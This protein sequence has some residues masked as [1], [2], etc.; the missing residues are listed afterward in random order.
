MRPDAISGGG[1]DGYS[2][3]M[4]SV[5]LADSGGGT[6]VTNAGEVD[7]MDSEEGGEAFTSGL[8]FV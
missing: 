4:D 2:S 1:A 5:I 8:C 7:C 6:D 3:A